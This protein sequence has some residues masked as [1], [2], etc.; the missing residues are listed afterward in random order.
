MEITINNQSI[1]FAV[2]NCWNQLHYK[3]KTQLNKIVTENSD[4][5]FMQKVEID[6]KSFL[7]IMRA[8]NLQPQIGRASCRERV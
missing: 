1:F 7:L 6:K 8:V 2:E 5:E 4:N 3:L